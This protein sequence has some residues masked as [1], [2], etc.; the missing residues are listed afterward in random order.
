M[1]Y[2][3]EKENGTTALENNIAILSQGDDSIPVYLAFWKNSVTFIGENLNK[4]SAY[5][6]VYAIDMNVINLFVFPAPYRA[7]T[8]YVLSSP[9]AWWFPQASSG[10]WPMS[11]RDTT[12]I[13]SI[14][15][16]TVK[17]FQ[18]ITIQRPEKKLTLE[19]FEIKYEMPH[20]KMS[21]YYH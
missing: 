1:S 12:Y 14:Y 13:W 15:Q 4:G 2:C 17:H 20:I 7:D 6:S 10:H 8:H 5:H 18:V 19:I 3:G 16:V 21:F 9:V 11:I